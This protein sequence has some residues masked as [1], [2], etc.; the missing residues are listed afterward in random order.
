MSCDVKDCVCVSIVKIKTCVI[1]SEKKDKV[2]DLWTSGTKQ[3]SA[4]TDC[5]GQESNKKTTDNMAG[6]QHNVDWH[7]CTML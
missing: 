1:F 4:K 7:I 6:Q 5:G 3:R 2:E